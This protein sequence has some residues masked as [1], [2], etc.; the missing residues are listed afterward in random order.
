[1]N[2]KISVISII[3]FLLSI[4]S[5]DVY[6]AQGSYEYIHDGIEICENRWD[7]LDTIQAKSFIYRAEFA[8]YYQPL[9]K[10][11]SCMTGYDE[12]FIYSIF[13]YENTTKQG[14]AASKLWTEGFNPGGIK[15]HK[16]KY[17]NEYM[18]FYDDCEKEKCKFAKFNSVKEGLDAWINL[19]NCERYEDC[20]GIDLESTFKCFR[21][22][23]YH[24]S[25]RYEQRYFIATEYLMQFDN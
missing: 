22:K 5:L 10:Y 3:L 11:V 20:R 16:G 13:L 4:F 17:S 14:Y 21:D 9:F 19:I 24:T 15:Y 12:A 7:S 18:S 6:T 1:M 2:K 23:S 8:S 25:N